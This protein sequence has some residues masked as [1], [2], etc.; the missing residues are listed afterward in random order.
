[1]DCHIILSNKTNFMV[2][3]HDNYH[4]NMSMMNDCIKGCLDI[5]DIKDLNQLMPLRQVTISY[6]G[7][8][9]SDIVQ[10]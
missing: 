1:M 8:L 6:R 4:E 3:F 7:S 5:D 10:A 2:I 9:I